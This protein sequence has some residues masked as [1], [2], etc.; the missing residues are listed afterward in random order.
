MNPAS[1]ALIRMGA[2]CALAALSDVVVTGARLK[3][4]VRLIASLL[5]VLALMDMANEGL[6][7]LG[8]RP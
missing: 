1:D 5:L 4:G 8:L 7:L 6:A 2:L 3:S